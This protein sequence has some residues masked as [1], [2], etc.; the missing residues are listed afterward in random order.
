MLQRSP[1]AL[2]E[3]QPEVLDAAG[4]REVFMVLAMETTVR[5]VLLR[6][7]RWD[8]L[9]ETNAERGVSAE[10]TLR[11]ARD[12]LERGDADGAQIHYVHDAVEWWDTVMRTEAG[13]RRVRIRSGP[14]A[15]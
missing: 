13:F 1:L 3:R 9:R 8:E 14:S 12:A 5:G 4:L 11:A 2:A 10:T 6:G 15:D 7:E